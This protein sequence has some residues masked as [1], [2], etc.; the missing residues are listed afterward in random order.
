M[1]IIA[2]LLLIKPGLESDLIGAAL[3]IIVIVTQVMAR[4][5]ALKAALKPG[6]AAE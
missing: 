6:I 4:K 2:G 1:L 5:A 3:A